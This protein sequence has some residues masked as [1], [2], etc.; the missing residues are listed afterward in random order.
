M[1]AVGQ[2]RASTIDVVNGDDDDDD[3]D[4]VDDV[5]RESGEPTST[6]RRDHE[7]MPMPILAGG[8]RQAADCCWMLDAGCWMLDVGPRRW[9]VELGRDVVRSRSGRQG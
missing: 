4:D 6:I 8:R 1:T 7:R 9:A 3:D 2:K 5:G